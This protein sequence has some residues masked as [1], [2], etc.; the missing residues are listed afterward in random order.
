MNIEQAKTIAISDLLSRL[1]IHPRKTNAHKLLYLSPVR[2]E[3]SPSFWVD[4]K[5]NRWHDFGTGEGGDVL[6][7]VCAYLNFY[8]E[9]ATTVDA[10]RWLGNMNVVPYHFPAIE[11]EPD[12]PP[13]PT[14]ILRAKKPV[15]H[16]AL[17]RYLEGRGI[18]LAI[19]RSHF[20]QL[21]I[22]NKTTGK[23]FFAL[24]F[25]NEESGWELRNPF[26]KGCLGTK[27]ISFVRGSTP[28][29]DN[30]HLFEGVFDYLSALCQLRE[31]GMQ[32]QFRGAALILNSLSCMAQVTAYIHN[33]GYR[34]AYSWLDND[35]AGEKATA[36]FKEFCQTQDGLTHKPMNALYAPH[37]DVNAWHMHRHN[38]SL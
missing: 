27:A 29:P 16:P 19:A 32:P 24:G 5:T 22:R 2:H 10:L 21:H 9:A 17:I 28:K 34:I 1:D 13:D 25:A 36:T 8:R 33:Y 7:L 23:S 12:S 3:K 11:R 38:L 15:E 31:R 26:F 4:T 14:L 18:P 35:K 20:K 30:I 6:D 37:D